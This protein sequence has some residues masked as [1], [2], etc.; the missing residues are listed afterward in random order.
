[1][2]QVGRLVPC[3][4]PGAVLLSPREPAESHDNSNII[5]TLKKKV[6]SG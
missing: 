1:M 6:T 5:I 2:A 3:Q 4:P